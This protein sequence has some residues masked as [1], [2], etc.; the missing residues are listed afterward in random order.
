MKYS[1]K[2]IFERIAASPLALI[3]ALVVLGFLIKAAWGS[4]Q[5]A[6]QSS[7]KLS[8]EQAELAKLEQNQNDLSSQVA[9][10]STDQGVEA[11]MRT[12]FKAVKEGEQVAVIVDDGSQTAAAR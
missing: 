1:N 6:V 10:L 12:K 11:E 2:P 4:H 9:Y 3:A 7:Q 5:K 8:T